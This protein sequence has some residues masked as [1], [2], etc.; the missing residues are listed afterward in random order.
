LIGSLYDLQP[1]VESADYIAAT[2]GFLRRQPKRSLVIVLTNLRDEDSSD[3]SAS[4]RLL[5]RRHLVLVANLRETVLDELM[6]VPVDNF[7]AARRYA[8]TCDYLDAREQGQRQ[9]Q[10]LGGRV[11]DTPPRELPMALVNQYLAIK[12]SGR[13]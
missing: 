12:R 8:A 2:E 10:A 4:L 6:A 9:L 1:G 7:Q 5:L 3:L 13:L 11:L